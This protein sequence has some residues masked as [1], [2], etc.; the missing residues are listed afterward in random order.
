MSKILAFSGSGRKHSYNFAALKAAAQGAIDAGAEVTIVDMS[1]FADIPIFTEDLEAE[2]GMPEKAKAFKELLKSHDAFLIASPEYNSGYSALFKNVIDW[3]S[4][5]EDGEKP[6][7]A[8]KGKSAALIAASPG[9]LGGIRVLVPVRLLLSNIGI[10]VLGDQLSISHVGNL[11]NDQHEISDEKTI[12]KLH[13]IAKQ[14]VA[15]TA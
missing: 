9:G 13:G 2:Q 1:E 7:E 14:L 12:A 4:R 5:K 10:N 3:A 8:F 15:M 6:L 11:V